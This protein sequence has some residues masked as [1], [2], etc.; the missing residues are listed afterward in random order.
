MSEQLAAL[1]A[2]ALHEDLEHGGDVTATATIPADARGR[3]RVVARRPGVL[4][5]LVAARAVVAAVDPSVAVEELASDGD[6][7]E[8]GTPVLELDGATR[9]LLAAERTMLNFL[10]HLSGVATETARYVEE[11]AGTRCALRDTRKTTPAMRELEKAAVR[12]GGGTNHRMGLYDGIL[13]KD[14]HVA[15]CGGVFEA[16]RQALGYVAETG[17]DVEVQ[18]EVDDVDQLREA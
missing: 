15:A 11:L 18:V 9:S 12:A 16:T 4:S 8:P 3:A 1:V 14:N 17:R 7:L 13:V 2:L 6:A 5:G 10:G